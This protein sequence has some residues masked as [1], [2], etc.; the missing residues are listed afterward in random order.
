VATSGIM[1]I[2]DVRESRWF[3]YKLNWGHKE[4]HTSSDEPTA[5]FSRICNR[6]LLQNT[7]LNGTSVVPFS[8]VP[9]SAMM[10]LPIAGK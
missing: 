3:D 7:V 5:Y 6:T 9:A 10:L 8:Q 4:T 2:T 1:L